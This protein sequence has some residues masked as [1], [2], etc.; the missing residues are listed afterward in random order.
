MNTAV[1]ARPWLQYT[2]S[3]RSVHLT[4]RG[5]H[6][7][8]CEVHTVH[9][10]RILQGGVSVYHVRRAAEQPLPA[11]LL[12]LI[13]AEIR[14]EVCAHAFPVRTDISQSTTDISQ[15]KSSL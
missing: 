13:F 8:P 7:P 2:A 5:V 9:V 15:S 1:Q 14:A 3:V 6:A 4:G 10:W 12:Q 11:E